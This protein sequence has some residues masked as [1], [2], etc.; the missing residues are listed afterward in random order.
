ML[1]SRTHGSLRPGCSSAT[2]GRAALLP[3]AACPSD[4]LPPVSVFLPRSATNQTF[5]VGF[6]NTRGYS[7]RQTRESARQTEGERRTRRDREGERD[8]RQAGGQGAGKF[9]ALH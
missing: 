9:M 3:A 8:R 1:P 2:P 5:G 7:Q 4:K 6:L